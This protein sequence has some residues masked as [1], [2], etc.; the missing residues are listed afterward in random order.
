ML[1][2]QHVP[3]CEV[4][5][6]NGQQK[7]SSSGM[8]PESEMERNMTRM[9]ALLSNSL[10]WMLFRVEGL[11]AHLAAVPS[12]CALMQ[13]GSQLRSICN[14]LTRPP[15]PLI[16]TQTSAEPACAG[17]VHRAPIAIMLAHVAARSACRA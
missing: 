5:S 8:G 9:P 6:V 1:T 12:R 11:A 14:P 17:R 7:S 2:E 4:G 13:F 3:G 16:D 15:L 10:V